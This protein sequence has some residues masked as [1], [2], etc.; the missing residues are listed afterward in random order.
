[1]QNELKQMDLVSIRSLFLE[2]MQ[3]FLIALEIESPEQLRL[4]KQRIREIDIVL[5]EKKR[6]ANA[7]NSLSEFLNQMENKRSVQNNR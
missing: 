7:E 4:R 3:A 6:L 2:E 5:E 1:M